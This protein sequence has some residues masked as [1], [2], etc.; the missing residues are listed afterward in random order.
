[1]IYDVPTAELLQ[2]SVSPYVILYPQP[3]DPCTHILGYLQ[4]SDTSA[5][6]ALYLG[7]WGA[8]EFSL[9]RGDL[10]KTICPIYRLD[11]NHHLEGLSQNLHC[12][13]G[14]EMEPSSGSKPI[15]FH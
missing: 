1:M 11:A 13:V 14:R 9:G 12:S 5:W 4:T 15:L 7:I 10:D 8:S 6:W 2:I 3:S